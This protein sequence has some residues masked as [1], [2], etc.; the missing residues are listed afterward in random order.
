MEALMGKATKTTKRPA[1]KPA[2]A[3]TATRKAAPAKAKTAKR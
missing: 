1:A 3:K 2:K